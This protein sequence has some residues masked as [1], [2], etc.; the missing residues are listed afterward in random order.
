VCIDV[1]QILSKLSVYVYNMYEVCVGVL[2]CVFRF[3]F[4]SK[5]VASI[6]RI[7]DQMYNTHTHSHT[8]TEREKKRHKTT[9]HII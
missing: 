1:V 6:S 5:S 2:L 3:L 9:E 8:H 7:S 4:I